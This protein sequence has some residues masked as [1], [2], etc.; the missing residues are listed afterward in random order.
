[1]TTNRLYSLTQEAWE[2]RVEKA[3]AEGYF[4][5]DHNA[6]VQ[7]YG[8]HVAA[9]RGIVGWSVST[10]VRFNEQG[11]TTVEVM[12]VNT[13]SRKTTLTFGEA[14]LLSTLVNLAGRSAEFIDRTFRNLRVHNATVVSADAPA[15]PP[16]AVTT[17]P[18]PIVK[19]WGACPVCGKLITPRRTMV[20]S[21]GVYRPEWLPRYCDHGPFSFTM[22]GVLGTLPEVGQPATVQIGSDT[23]AAKVTQVSKTGSY[24]MVQREGREP[25]KATWREEQHAYCV[26]RSRGNWV[27]I[28][29]AT[30]SL[31]REF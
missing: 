26:V 30:T 10:V 16:P 29:E 3:L 31:A 24:V 9:S 11:A 22:G 21:V 17:V 20:E 8:D 6:V 1:M 2:A 19:K 18:V 7:K 25:E 27:T 28:G 13:E 5:R 23:Y 12:V 14:A 15:A 4:V